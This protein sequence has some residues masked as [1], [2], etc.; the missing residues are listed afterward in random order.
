MLQELPKGKWFCSGECKKIYLALNNLLNS[1]SEKLPESSLEPIREKLAKEGSDA[2]ADIDV[3]WRILSGKATSR[4]TRLLLSE[5]VAIFHVSSS[6]MYIF[7]LTLSPVLLF[8][9]DDE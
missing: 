7:Y 4:E 5:A 8:S 1:G 9:R 2:E 3:S 6:D